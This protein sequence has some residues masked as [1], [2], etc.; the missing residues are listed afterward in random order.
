MTF[1]LDVEGA[2]LESLHRVA[3]LCARRVLEVGC[4]DGR[5][6]KGF[7]ADAA[8]VFAFDN[9]ASL[10]AAASRLLQPE[11]QQG[12]VRLA[13]ASAVDVELPSAAFDVGVFSWSY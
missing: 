7:A 4:G 11:I 5:L 2:H 9:N 6:T 3:D 13:V 8:S 1:V 10:V 12:R